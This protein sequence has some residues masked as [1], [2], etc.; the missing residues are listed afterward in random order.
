M[1]KNKKGMI[2]I[3]DALVFLVIMTIVATTIFSYS[4]FEQHNEPMAKSVC[5]ELFSINLEAGDLYDTDDTTTYPISVLIAANLNTGND[6]RVET[7]I[8]NIMDG[9]VPEVYGYSISIS[10]NEHIIIA[11]R[12]AT[13]EMTS[14][15]TGHIDVAHTNGLDVDV[16]VF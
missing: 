7:L 2:A 15:Y 13:R 10:L 6:E 9:L 1:I 11:E 4:A 12:N 16:I 14:E 5:D 8:K 3:M